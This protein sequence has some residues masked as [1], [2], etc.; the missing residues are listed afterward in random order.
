MQVLTDKEGDMTVTIAANYN[1]PNTTSQLCM[2]LIALDL[3][4][5]DVDRDNDAICMFSACQ[6]P[7]SQPEHS[8]P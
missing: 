8:S 2:T 3:S 6:S 1:A 7:A 5:V 4:G